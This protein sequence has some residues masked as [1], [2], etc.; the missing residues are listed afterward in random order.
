MNAA[1]W[2]IAL[3]TLAAA[4]PS[5]AAQSVTFEKAAPGSL[6]DAFE[7]A[8]TGQGG[9]GEW[10]I[11]DDP[12]ANG[13]RALAQLSAERTNNRFP[14]AIYRQASFKDG[15]VAIH[16]KP[17]SGQVDQAGGVAIRL[18]NADNY[19]IARANALED[20]VRFYRV[21]KGIRQ[22]IAGA[23]TKVTSGAWHSLTIRA[24]A[25]RFTILYDGQTLFTATDKT[26]PDAGKVALWTKADS[27]THFDRIAIRQLP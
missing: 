10:K 24:E 7:T 16:F 17:I 26:F 11:V 15:E 20:N 27:V 1:L 18:A 22:E 12:T 4:T 9:D 14:L 3:G 2:F 23:D 19:Y 6:P 5:A 21:I 13:G 25:D 8:R